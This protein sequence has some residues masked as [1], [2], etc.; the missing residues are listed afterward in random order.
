MHPTRSD[1]LSH[2]IF[3]V[4]MLGSAAVDFPGES[5][6]FS[7][8]P[9]SRPQPVP[10]DPKEIQRVL[11]QER[12]DRLNRA[13]ESRDP[14]APR[15]RRRGARAGPLSSVSSVLPNHSVPAVCPSASESPPLPCVSVSDMGPALAACSTHDHDCGQDDVAVADEVPNG[16][17]VSGFTSSDAMV[18]HAVSEHLT[19][20]HSSRSLTYESGAPQ[21]SERAMEQDEC[22]SLNTG[23]C[24]AGVP[25]HE[26]EHG[27][28][29]SEAV[30]AIEIL[31]PRCGTEETMTHPALHSPRSGPQAMRTHLSAPESAHEVLRPYGPQEEVSTC[32]MPEQTPEGGG[33]APNGDSPRHASWAPTTSIPV[34]V[35]PSS[36]TNNR[37]RGAPRRLPFLPVPPNL[38]LLH[39]HAVRTQLS[40]ARLIKTERPL[41]LS[42]MVSRAEIPHAQPFQP[43]LIAPRN[44]DRSSPIPPVEEEEDEDSTRGATGTG[45]RALPSVD[46]LIVQHIC[47]VFPKRVARARELSRRPPAY[48]VAYRDVLRLRIIG[49]ALADLGIGTSQSDRTSVTVQEDGRPVVIHRDDVMVMLGMRPSTYR[50]V[51]SR[52]EKVQSVYTWLGQNKHVWEE[53]L[54]RHVVTSVEH[55]AFHAMKALF[56]PARL[57]T[58]RHIPTEPLPAGIHDAIWEPCKTFI[59][60]AQ[61]IVNRYDLIKSKTLPVSPD[62]YDT[63]ETE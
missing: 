27:Q 16:D 50:S 4:L 49:G 62:F 31:A 44:L 9:H 43:P 15:R 11:R 46:P 19:D 33:P 10:G 32:A 7:A 55:R 58:R 5:S 35:E 3:E 24:S 18:D 25:M 37:V 53:Q 59:T 29:H 12:L 63:E 51:R 38:A 40:S 8:Q 39:H 41:Q 61:A 54:G 56:G 26:D 34:R 17:S 23:Q 45:A 21:G 48:G 13:R 47:R 57:P 20:A 30:T 1:T 42:S 36:E 6:Q 60:W 14:P 22:A 28:A 2:L 52:L